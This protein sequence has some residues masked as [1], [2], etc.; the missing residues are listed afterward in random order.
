M[1]RSCPR[2]PGDP[3][4]TAS[5]FAGHSHGPARWVWLGHLQ[6]RPLCLLHP[7]DHR[8]GTGFLWPI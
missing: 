1:S 7:L 3:A 6:P 5:P 8:T 4:L 2:C